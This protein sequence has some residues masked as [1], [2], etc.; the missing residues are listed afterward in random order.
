M[1][2]LRVSGVEEV[3]VAAMK[4]TGVDPSLLKRRDAVPNPRGGVRTVFTLAGPE[5]C[6]CLDVEVHLAAAH[7]EDAEAV[8]AIPGTRRAFFEWSGDLGNDT[9]GAS[10]LGC[11]TKAVLAGTYVER[12]WWR[13]FEAIAQCETALVRASRGSG[14][15]HWLGRKEE[16][17]FAP[18]PRA[19]ATLTP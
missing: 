3:L 9:R 12:V 17:H 15:L 7:A 16:R 13:N 1:S 14:G 19:S 5:D 4:A 11:I 2:R 8:L 10:E 6:A 18:Y